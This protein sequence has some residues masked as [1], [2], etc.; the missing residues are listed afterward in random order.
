[1]KKFLATVI[2]SIALSILNVEG[3]TVLRPNIPIILR[4]ETPRR[5]SLLLD[6]IKPIKDYIKRI[7]LN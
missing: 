4:T 1:M 5:P 2:F 3:K 7:Y 6:F